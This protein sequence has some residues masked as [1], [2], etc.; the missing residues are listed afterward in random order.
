VTAPTPTPDTPDT[1][2]PLDAGEREDGPTCDCCGK[3]EC[4]DAALPA[5]TEPRDC[6]YAPI[7]HALRDS[8]DCDYGCA[9]D[10]TTQ[11][12]RLWVVDAVEAILTAQ[13]ANVEALLAPGSGLSRV[14]KDAIRAALSGDP[15]PEDTGSESARADREGQGREGAQ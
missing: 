14:A 8:K 6:L 7:Y 3:A 15:G 9:R 11:A 1:P 2:A 5:F 10:Y 12:V 13:L 4:P